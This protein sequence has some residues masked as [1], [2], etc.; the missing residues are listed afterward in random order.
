MLASQG[1][2]TPHP[3]GGPA[4]EPMLAPSSAQ[5]LLIADRKAIKVW[6][7]GQDTHPTMHAAATDK[8]ALHGNT[9]AHAC[10]RQCQAAAA[11]EIYLLLSNAS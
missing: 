10:G 8:H 4:A 5:R 6:L 11:A 9:P 3:A 7:N 1:V 2:H